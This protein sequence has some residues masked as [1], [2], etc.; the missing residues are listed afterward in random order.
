MNCTAAPRLEATVPDSGSSYAQ[1]G[2][3]AHAYCARKLKSFMGLDTSGEDMEIAQLNGQYHTGEMDEYTDTYRN[4][5]LE[6]FEAARAA[7]RDA[8]LLIET[9]LDFSEYVPEAFGT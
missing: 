3:L 2:S 6:K 9:R 1:E 7:T 4:I 5:V 8:R